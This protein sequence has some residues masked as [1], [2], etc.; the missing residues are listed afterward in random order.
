MQAPAKMA[1]V[2]TFFTLYESF[3]QGQKQPVQRSHPINCETICMILSIT[4]VM[5]RF[6]L[7][8]LR[9]VYRSNGLI[10]D[11]NQGFVK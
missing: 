9:R 10:V 4:I 5:N 3:D 8:L 11:I 1:Y 2:K 6:T 7:N